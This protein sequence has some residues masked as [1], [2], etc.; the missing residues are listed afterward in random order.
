MEKAIKKLKEEYQK[1]CDKYNLTMDN[2]ENIQ[3][4]ADLAVNFRYAAANAKDAKLQTIGIGFI[5]IIFALAYFGLLVPTI[6]AEV[7]KDNA[8]AIFLVYLGAVSVMCGG[9]ITE[10]IEKFSKYNKGKREFIEEEKRKEGSELSNATALA[11][12]NQLIEERNQYKIELET[13]LPNITALE[14]I[15]TS[16]N[17]I[18]AMLDNSDN[19]QVVNEALKEEWNAYLKEC[20]KEKIYE[21]RIAMNELPNTNI[22]IPKSKLKNLVYASKEKK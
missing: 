15:I 18:E 1:L 7:L 19:C 17:P 12:A 11:Y 16:E 14:Q 21:T 3:D 6:A 8:I 4:L 10:V 2:Y 22:S 20:E 9:L 5:V 13:M